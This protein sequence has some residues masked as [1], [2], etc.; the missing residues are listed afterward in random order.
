MQLL[1]PP[2]CRSHLVFFV[3]CF[4]WGFAD[5][6]LQKLGWLKSIYCVN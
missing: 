6:A 1:P 5:Y 3:L 4:G 2:L